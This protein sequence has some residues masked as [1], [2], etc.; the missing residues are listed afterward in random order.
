MFQEFDGDQ[1]D[2]SLGDF[3]SSESDMNEY[4]DE[5]IESSS[6]DDDDSDRPLDALEVAELAS[7]MDESFEDEMMEVGSDWDDDIDDEES[8]EHEL[9]EMSEAEQE[10]QDPDYEIINIEDQNVPAITKPGAPRSV[11]EASWPSGGAQEPS[12]S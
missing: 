5:P 1:P 3:E 12:R 6:G 4:S 2:S 7:I 11:S 10:E 9:E 8:I